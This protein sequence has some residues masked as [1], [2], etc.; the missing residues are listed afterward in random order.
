MV[1]VDL[2]LPCLLPCYQKY[3]IPPW[4]IKRLPNHAVK[5]VSGISPFST[6]ARRHTISYMII[7]TF[8][9][10]LSGEKAYSQ[11]LEAFPFSNF[12]CSSHISQNGL[13]CGAPTQDMQ[14]FHVCGSPVYH[15]QNVLFS[16]SPTLCPVIAIICHIN[17]F[18]YKK[19]PPHLD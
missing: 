11:L 19:N 16:G 6:E 2:C 10:F 9:L 17:T 4:I 8:I 14:F 5:A 3:Y 13:D 1:Q 7:M 18:L 12:R 15:S